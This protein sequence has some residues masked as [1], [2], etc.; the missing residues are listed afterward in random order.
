MNQKLQD[1]ENAVFGCTIFLCLI[2]ALI[3]FTCNSV[4]A[5]R[6]K[7][8]HAAKSEFLRSIGVN[9][10]KTPPGYVVDHIIPLKRGGCD[11]P[12]N[13]QLQTIAEG[14]AKDKTE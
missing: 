1:E 8:S 14:K 2:V 3:L 13:M 11:C 12:S 7:R 10:G 5:G 6:I 9:N 4:D